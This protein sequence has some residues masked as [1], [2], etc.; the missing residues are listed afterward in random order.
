M[1]DGKTILITGGTGSF[2]NYIASKL[3][4]MNT[5][6]VRILSRHENLQFDMKKRY[7]QFH[8]VLGDVRDYPRLME[9]MEGV[10]IVFHAA[11]LKQV[12]D[13]EIH[14]MEA[15][16]TN[17]IGANN[18]KRAAIEC[19]VEKVIYISTDKAVKPINVMGMTKGLQEKIFISPEFDYDTKF[20]GV[21]YGNILGSRGS[22]IPY[23]VELAKKKQPLPITHPE[24]TRFLLTLENAI[25]LVFYALEN[26]RGREIFVRKSPAANIADLANMIAECYGVNTFVSKIRPGEKIHEVLVQEEEMRR[27]KE[28]AE[29]FII[30]PH[31]EYENNSSIIREYT[32]DT[33][34]R[35]NKEEIKYLLETEGWFE[36]DISKLIV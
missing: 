16:K 25:K 18:V 19:N 22:V 23:F 8:Y 10:D 28:E 36:I 35:L 6:E 17:I 9:A 14:P 32:S 30:Y 7:P 24:M 15:I 20:I 27:A 13:C 31:G 33:T 12:P 11:A 3:I 29:Y 5:K 1:V 34:T 26:G 2:G 21:R 4:Q